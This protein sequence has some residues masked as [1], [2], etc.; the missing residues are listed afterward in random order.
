MKKDGFTLVEMLIVISIIAFLLGV[1]LPV[2]SFAG[3]LAR[4]VICRGNVRSIGLAF[5]LYHTTHGAFPGALDYP[6]PVPDLEEPI[7]DSSVDW[8]GRWWPQALDI[9][10]VRFSDQKHIL[11]CPSKNYT[12][13]KYKYNDLRGNY[14]ANWSVCKSPSAAIASSFPEF[15][16]MPVKRTSIHRP[17]KTL[18]LADS[19]Y[20]LLAW[21]HT[22]P[23]SHARA[24]KS[25]YEAFN[26]AYIPGA[27]VNAHK[28]LYPEQKPDA[29]D[30][31][32]PG[33]TVNCLFVDGHTE[34][35]KADDLA[36]EPLDHGQVENLTPLWKPR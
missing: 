8:T 32:H 27:S 31:R 28:S 4:G 6:T 24:P 13:L 3:Q 26:M 7:I 9:V 21:V 34:K 29:I 23:D 5:D 30:G 19:G 14:G 33:R 12:D 2:F 17:D 20:A 16:G 1:V 15:S 10:P 35:R 18:L 25:S 11:R 36:V 22:L